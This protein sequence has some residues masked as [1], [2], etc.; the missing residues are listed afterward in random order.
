[1]IENIELFQPSWL[2]IAKKELGQ[3]EI[4]GDKDNERIIE[5]HRTTT[6]KAA[7][8]EVPWCSSFVN[9]AIRR[10][11]FKGTDSARARSWLSWGIDF[12]IPAYGCV[13]VLSRG[14]VGQGHVGFFVGRK[15]GQVALLGGNQSNAVSIT[16][17]PESKILGYRWPT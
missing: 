9:W 10:A 16:W 17:F 2:A 4:A 3:V 8:D 12:R 5:Y 6:L 14:K 15:A 13:V 7:D 1:M 11:G